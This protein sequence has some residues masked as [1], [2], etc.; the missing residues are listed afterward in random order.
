MT[1]DTNL[2]ISE[3]Q[4]SQTTLVQIDEL[5]A[6]RIRNQH[7][8]ALIALQ[9]AQLLEYTP[10]GQPPVIWLSETAEFR[11]GSAVRG[12]IPVCWPWFGDL[13][14]NP[15]AVR[16]LAAAPAPA[17]G[18]VRAQDWV[19]RGVIETDA[20]TEIRLAYPGT[21]LPTHWR[22]DLELTLRIG[23]SLELQLST[24]NT[25]GAPLVFSQAL[26]SYFAISDVEHVEIAGL[27]QTPYLDTLDQWRERRQPGQLRIDGETDRVYLETPELLR[28]DDA[29]WRRAL[30]LR[31]RHSRSA[32]V[33]N[34]WIEKSK[35]LSQFKPD[36]WRRMLC[37]E[38]A[39]VMSDVVTLA[40]GEQ[41]QLV[42]EIRS[43]PA[44]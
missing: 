30:Q 1:T 14:R 25:G 32:V 31:T 28:I 34:P 19:L 27:D 22:A 23:A 16:T 24:R 40:P 7:A 4:L 3:R 36:A 15:D 43:L 2:L 6:L 8:D 17:H 33:W 42:V 44:A 21:H 35:R 12:G 26:H 5:P 18:L 11:R 38:S 9:G 41:Q 37:I 39:N 10:R 29:Q 13:A 20:H